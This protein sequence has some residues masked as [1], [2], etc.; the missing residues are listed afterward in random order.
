LHNKS[1]ARD[2]DVENERTQGKRIDDK[3]TDDKRT[4]DKRTDDKRTDDKLIRARWT[5]DSAR[6]ACAIAPEQNV[7]AFGAKLYLTSLA[8]RHLATPGA[9]VAIRPTGTTPGNTLL[10]FVQL[11]VNEHR[12]QQKKEDS[13]TDAEH[14]DRH[15]KPVDFRQQFRLLFLHVRIVIIQK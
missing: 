7:T 13:G 8:V 3:R 10:N 14:P 5:K 12:N 2:D 1:S 15:S 6:L 4:D 11:L 9:T